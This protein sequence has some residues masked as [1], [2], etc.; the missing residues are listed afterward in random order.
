MHLRRVLLGLALIAAAGPAIACDCLMPAA[1]HWSACAVRTIPQSAERE[2]DRLWRLRNRSH[3][4]PQIVHADLRAERRWFA[5]WRP[6][7]IAHCGRL[8]DAQAK[9]LREKRHG[10]PPPFDEIDALAFGPMPWTH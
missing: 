10:I 7:L 8:E 1:E 4:R 5:R 3:Q 6:T 2:A 9:D